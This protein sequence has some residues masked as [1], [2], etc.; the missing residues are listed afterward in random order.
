[1]PS[2]SW[3]FACLT[4]ALAAGPALLRT[5]A[6]A[7]DQS[8]AGFTLVD[9]DRVVLLG[10]TF[11]ERDAAHG[12][13]ET[14]LTARF[15][16]HK[17]QFRNLGRS[18][19]NVF[20]EARAGFGT[21]ADGFAHLKSHVLALRPTVI[22]LNYGANES[23]EGPAG[24][25]TFVEGLNTLLATLDETKARIV[26]LSPLKHEDLG[27]P[28]P[29]PTE[30][31]RN[32]KLYSD[33][34]AKVAAKRNDKFV[35]LFEL[36]GDKLTPPAEI[37]LTDNGLHLTAY[38][39]WRA[40]PVI[41]QGLGL[42]ARRWQIEID[43]R[44]RNITANGT[45]VSEAKFSDSGV[46]FETLDL[47]LPLPPA[48]AGSPERGMLA[49]ATRVLRVYGLA[50][51]RYALKIGGRQIGLAT[52][53]QLAGGAALGSG[54]DFEQAAQLRQAIVAK[55]QLYFYRWRPQNETYLFGF[56]KHEQGQNAV[57]IPQ[58]DLLVDAQETEIQRLCVPVSRRYE[59]VK[60]EGK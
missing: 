6:P 34:I 7:G 8:P 4:I 41:E 58:F 22:L 21:A 57:E 1:M 16:P 17:I 23:F 51:G 11:I 39:Y 27:R 38:G 53:E 14:A 55:N 9:G 2:A 29:D 13:L 48:P 46:A 25:P 18:G 52:A 5:A 15:Q 20:G 35:N 50:S 26:F 19:D 24:L 44:H 12:Y 3:R 36:L 47:Q 56:R 59:I 54:P 60:V 42:P 37:P 45:T 31:N 32:L 40:A 30:H 28:L 33:A 43:A 10:G 49:A